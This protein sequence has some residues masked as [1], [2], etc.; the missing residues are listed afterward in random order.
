LVEGLREQ[1]E[2]PFELAQVLEDALAAEAQLVDTVRK[3]GLEPP[4]V[5]TDLQ[6]DARL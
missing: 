2:E 4:L 3:L 1:L 5:L 6:V